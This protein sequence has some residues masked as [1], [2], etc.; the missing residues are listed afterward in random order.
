V[1]E[2]V[3]RET[4]GRLAACLAD[5]GSFDV[6]CG[7]ADDVPLVAFT[8]PSLSREAATAIAA[9]LAGLLGDAGGE[10]ITV[11]TVRAA[12]VVTAASTPLVVAVRRPNTAVAFAE[13]RAAR[14]A[15][16]AGPRTGGGRTPAREL[17]AVTVE[18]RVAGVAGTLASF[19]AV[20]PAVLSH[21]SGGGRVY[22]FREPG[23]EAERIAS[24]AL[25]AWDGFGH[26]AAELGPVVSIVFRQGRRRML[27]RPV[28]A[29]SALLAAAGPVARPGRAW[30]DA[31]R[32]AVALEAR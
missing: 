24:L 25:A 28:G 31:E 27:V 17:S 21:G 9:R 6:W 1:R 13:M 26:A 29:G 16:L 4:L 2:I 12:V 20:E 19:G 22:V 18:P 5:V 15:S 8:A 7:V 11:R 32:A 14:A 23:Q 30:R 3:D 10:Q